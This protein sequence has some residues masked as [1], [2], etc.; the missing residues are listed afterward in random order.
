MDA[1]G[2]M[3]MGSS[4]GSSPSKGSGLGMLVLFGGLFLIWW[5]L[6][7]APQMKKQ[8]ERQKMVDSLKK[9]DRVVTRGGMIGTIIGVKEKERI[10]V[11]RVAENVKIEVVQAA[12]EGV[13]EHE[14]VKE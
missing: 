8:K 5:F 2:L 13:L 6:F 3:A 7:L 10:V 11:L 4:G 9:G 12:V 14:E 1:Y